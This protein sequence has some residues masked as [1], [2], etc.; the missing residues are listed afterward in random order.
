MTERL[1]A[2][3]T[4]L[5]EAVEILEQWWRWHTLSARDYYAKYPLD[6]SLPMAH[7]P[8]QHYNALVRRAGEFLGR[9]T[10]AERDEP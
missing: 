1:S 5:A 2:A 8:Q 6:A 10:R 9:H 3:D 4:R 7:A